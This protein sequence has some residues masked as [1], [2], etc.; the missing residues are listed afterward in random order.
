[1][2][3]AHA[4]LGSHAGHALG[5][6][7]EAFHPLGDESVVGSGRIRTEAIAKG[8]LEALEGRAKVARSEVVPEP[9]P[10]VS[11]E[12]FDRNDPIG[13]CMEGGHLQPL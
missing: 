5:G 10:G 8:P 1:M 13:D 3:V 12:L 7:V 4:E 11:P 2:A 9:R 6:A